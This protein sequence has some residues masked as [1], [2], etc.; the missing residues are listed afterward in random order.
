M[1][2]RPGVAGPRCLRVARAGDAQLGPHDG[3]LGRGMALGD[4]G[5]ELLAGLDDADAGEAAEP[6]LA[7]ALDGRRHAQHQ[8]RV[9]GRH[10][11]GAALAHR[12]EHVGAQESGKLAGGVGMALVERRAV[13]LRPQ[14]GARRR[15]GDQASAIGHHPPDLAQH[16]PHLLG[17]LDG[18][19]QEHAV[20]RAVGQGQVV[21][22]DQGGEVAA[23]ARPARHALLRRH[24]GQGALRFLAERPQEG[25]GIAQA[26]HGLAAHVRPHFA[27]PRAQ[28]PHRHLPEGAAVKLVEVEDVRPHVAILAET[29]PLRPWSVAWR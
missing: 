3:E 10:E 22:V 11:E 17:A 26:Q 23:L 20:D 12:R 5:I 25:R 2:R 29:A 15:H 4:A 24:E 13:D 28:Q 9:G 18:M 19:D 8:P 1:L 6:A 7:E 14:A 21:L 16:R 27:Q